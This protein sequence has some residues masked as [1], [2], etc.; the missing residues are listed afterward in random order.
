MED[1]NL[2]EKPPRSLESLKERQWKIIDELYKRL[3]DEDLTTTEFTK[4]AKTLADHINILQKIELESPDK[5]PV[6]EPS[7]G[8]FVAKI[9]PRA[10]RRWD[11]RSWKRKLSLNRS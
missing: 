8:E 1:Q 7:L 4:A 11:M 10:H 5:G 3:D 6:H 9:K 2:K